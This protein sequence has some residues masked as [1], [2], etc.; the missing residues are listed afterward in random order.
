MKSL[1][2]LSTAVVAAAALLA[3][4]EASASNY[5][6]DYDYCSAR[7]TRTSG[8][9]EFIQDWVQ[10]DDANLTIAYRGY[11]RDHFA[12]DEINFYVRLNG[13]DAFLPASPGANG[14]AYAIVRSGPY[15]CHYCV[16]YYGGD[17][18]GI[19]GWVC[20]WPTATD[21]HLMFWAWNQS[22]ANA[23]DIEVAAEANGWWDSNW[24]QNYEARFEQAS[25][26]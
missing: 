24:G 1:V 6:P 22:S 14:D 8:P 15:D 13:H 12:D 26:F 18:E 17:C 5:P 11:L 20:S 23:W 4:A 10:H 19:N 25:C 7:Y 9:F 3:P 16:S 2:A 21:D